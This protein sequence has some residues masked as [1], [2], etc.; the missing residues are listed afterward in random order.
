MLIPAAQPLSIRRQG[1]TEYDWDNLLGGGILNGYVV[2]EGDRVLVEKRG[3]FAVDT[4]I[5]ITYDTGDFA[6]NAAGINGTASVAVYDSS[7]TDVLWNYAGTDRGVI[8]SL[9]GSPTKKIYFDCLDGIPIAVSQQTDVLAL[10]Q[11]SP[12][13]LDT[14]HTNK[15]T[16]LCWGG[17]V[18]SGRLYLGTGDS[19]G[20]ARVYNSSE[21]DP[22][23]YSTTD[24]ITAGSSSDQLMAIYRHYDHV[25]AF[26][27]N[28]CEFFY[29]NPDAPAS[30]S[31]LA[32]R[33]DIY[34]GVGIYSVNSIEMLNESLFFVGGVAQ[35]ANQSRYKPAVYAMQNFQISKI[36]TDAV[37]AWIADT[38]VNEI[39]G[40]TISVTSAGRPMYILNKN[41]SSTTG[42][43]TIVYDIEKGLW[44]FWAYGSGDSFK[45]VGQFDYESP[46]S[47][48]SFVMRDGTM[49]RGNT[50]ELFQDNSTNY[51]FG[52][53]TASTHYGT[54]KRKFFPEFSVIGDYCTT[55]SWSVRVSDDDFATYS[56]AR[57]LDATTFAKLPAMG[58]A[59]QRAWELS[60]TANTRARVEAFDL[61]NVRVGS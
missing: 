40:S 46:I 56:T 6:L 36:S 34:H 39:W 12:M 47:S 11:G 53:R 24:Y 33:M 55:G 22:G 59:Y 14:T 2:H 31:T 20:L 21:G 3:G 10:L 15:P 1:S 13:A 57:T 35:G 51:K 27:R 19:S 9:S 16:A 37:D 43:S 38:D 5:S 58:S 41:I 23:T 32:R 60:I 44:Y 61:G 28:S 52:I 48:P 26:G 25:V 49:L 42:D 54:N 18:I 45:M 29:V 17:A 30:G 7:A 4:T 50:N 8:A